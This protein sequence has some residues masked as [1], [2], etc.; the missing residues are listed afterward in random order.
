MKKVR[1]LKA[2]MSRY[3]TRILELFLELSIT[4]SALQATKLI[5]KDYEEDQRLD[6]LVYFCVNGEYP[7]E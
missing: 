7:D 3:E 5:Y 4:Q 2:A 6:S 1:I